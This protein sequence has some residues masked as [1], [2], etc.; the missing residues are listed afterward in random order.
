MNYRYWLV[1]Y[2]ADC[3][4]TGMTQ[5]VAYIRTT[6]GGHPSHDSCA[7]EML[8]D[9]CREKFGPEVAYVQG[10]AP[11]ANWIIGT[12]DHEAWVKAERR[13]WGGYPTTALRLTVSMERG[14]KFKILAEDKDPTGPPVPTYEDLQRENAELKER[15]AGSGEGKHDAER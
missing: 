14:G 9:F 4:E 15:I 13:R 5:N 7:V 8:R 1:P 10:C 2:G 11:C 3:N 6:W 12:S